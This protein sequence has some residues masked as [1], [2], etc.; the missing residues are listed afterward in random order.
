MAGGAAIDDVAILQHQYDA[1]DDA[2][3]RRGRDR[4]PDRGAACVRRP[5]F[6]LARARLTLAQPQQ[7]SRRHFGQEWCGVKEVVRTATSACLHREARPA[8]RMACGI[9]RA[10]DGQDERD[11]PMGNGAAEIFFR[12][13]PALSPPPERRRRPP[14]GRG[15]GNRRSGERCRS[16]R[17]RRSPP[18]SCRSGRSGAW[19]PARAGSPRC[20]S[21]LAPAWRRNRR[22]RYGAARRQEPRRAPPWR[23]D[24]ESRRRLQKPHPAGDGGGRA[25]P[26]RR[27]RCGF[28]PAAQ[29][30][31]KAGAFGGGR[32]R[33]KGD[34][35]RACRSHRT[36]RPAVDPRRA[37]TGEEQ[38][39]ESPARASRARS[40]VSQ[41][42]CGGRVCRCAGP[43]CVMPQ[44]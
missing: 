23:R 39:V 3:R 12:R 26:G 35:L 42:R 22:S 11:R 17:R 25:Q 27:A 16:R 44:Q 24:R 30:W 28:R 15:K 6:P 21:G 1:A 31:T 4:S 18:G 36:D 5:S 2:T 33:I 7:G 8:R 29:A 19:P 40:H 41:S 32:G 37:N 14:V 10:H 20:R 13:A 9:W 43:V 38:A 34:I